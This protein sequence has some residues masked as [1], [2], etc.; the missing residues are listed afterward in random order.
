MTIPF[1]KEDLKRF[2]VDERQAML[3]LICESLNEEEAPFE[4][5]D[6]QRAEL[7][8]RLEDIE[9][10]PDDEMP[11]EEVIASALRRLST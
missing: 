3:Q 6:V 4:L 2:S 7:D 5:T 8:R 9:K 10:H 11:A 1:T